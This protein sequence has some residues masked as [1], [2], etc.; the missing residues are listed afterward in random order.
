MAQSERAS[1]TGVVAGAGEAR[2]A[3]PRDESTDDVPVG[4]ASTQS[5]DV[6]GSTS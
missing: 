6:H 3:N 2:A 5:T 1:S 4:A